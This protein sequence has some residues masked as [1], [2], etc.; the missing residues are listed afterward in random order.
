MIAPSP[1]GLAHVAP[2]LLLPEG[3]KTW[4]VNWTTDFVRPSQ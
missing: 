3:G 1:A 2:E 4:E